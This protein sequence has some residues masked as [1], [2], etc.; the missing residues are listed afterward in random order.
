MTSNYKIPTLPLKIEL[1]SKAVLKQLT[2]SSRKLAELKGVGKTIPNENILISTLILQE[3]KDSSEIENI[4][5][6]HDE[7]FRAQVDDKNKINISTKEVQNYA[8]ALRKGFELIRKKRILTVN[9]IINIQGELEKNNAGVRKQLGTALKNDKTGEII[10]TPPQNEADILNYMKNLEDFIN[11]DDLS[12]VDSLI[13]MAII[14]HQ[15]ESIHPFY[16]GNGRTGRIINMLYL[17]TKDLLELPILY[18]SRYIIQNKSDYYRLLQDVRDNNNW[19][20]WILYILEGVEKTSIEAIKTIGQIKLL[21]SDYK[22]R[23][24]EEFPLMYSQDLINIIFKH[25]YTKIGFLE[26]ELR[27]TRKT[28]ASYLNKLSDSGFLVK[29]K[30]G[31]NNFYFNK[32][33]FDIFTG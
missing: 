20:E 30:I 1:E 6:T 33:L 11:D 14:H 25:P 9:D 31:K 3:A 32:P 21:M 27:I 8:S 26:S 15:F 29:N 28:A 4:I 13:K 12:D 24:R 5:T 18:L 19:E 22:K 23:I 2:K 16:D 10:Y 7:L 17:V